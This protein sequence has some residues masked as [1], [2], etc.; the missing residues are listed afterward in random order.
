[1]GAGQADGMQ[2]EPLTGQEVDDIDIRPLDQGG[3]P[4]AGGA[5]D[6]GRLDLRPAINLVINGRDPKPVVQPCQRRLVP[7]FPQPPQADHPDPEPN[8][9]RT[10]QAR[11]L[12]ILAAA[13]RVAKAHS[14][15]TPYRIEGYPKQGPGDPPLPTVSYP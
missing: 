2:A 10:D 6:L 15:L 12:A 7:G 5:A 9:L 13:P 4:L 8:L 1:R 11:L 3:Q 14:R